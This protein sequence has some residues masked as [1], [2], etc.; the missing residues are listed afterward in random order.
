MQYC[1]LIRE[2][3]IKNNGILN[4][5]WRVPMDVLHSGL[6]KER[7]PFYI[8]KLYVEDLMD[9]LSVQKEVIETLENRN[10]LAPLS[11][12]EFRHILL[13]GGSM[14]GVFADERLIAFRAMLVPGDDHEH[15]GHDIGLDPSEHPSIIYQEIS[16]VSPFYRGHRL[17]SLMATVLMEQSRAGEFKYVCAT[18]APFNIAS[19]KD[20]FSQQMEIAALKEKYG[21]ML[22]YVFVKHLHEEGMDYKEEQIIPMHNTASQ[23]ALLAEG[24]RGTGMTDSPKGWVVHYQK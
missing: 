10:S 22:R 5:N 9:I 13:D 6:L 11:E 19:L 20:K 21:G 16:N 24:W 14:V 3:K 17:Q 23:Q 1:F 7:D 18:V 15:L 2:I 12:E 4:S 8:R